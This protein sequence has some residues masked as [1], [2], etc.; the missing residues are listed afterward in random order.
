MKY[1]NDFEHRM[2]VAVHASSI[3]HSCVFQNCM[4]DVS[5]PCIIII[6]GLLS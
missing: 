1:E 3:S 5:I 2:F 6:V 4:K